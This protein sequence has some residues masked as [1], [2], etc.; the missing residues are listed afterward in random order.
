VDKAE[1]FLHENLDGNNEQERQLLN[2]GFE[3]G[4]AFALV[5]TLRFLISNPNITLDE[6]KSILIDTVND[7][8]FGKELKEVMM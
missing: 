2:K 7:A 1:K 8:K 4:N 5:D 6:F 3:I